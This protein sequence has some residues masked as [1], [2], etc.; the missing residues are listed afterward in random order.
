M[1]KEANDVNKVTNGSG[2]DH[3]PAGRD[4][5]RGSVAL[6]DLLPKLIDPICARKGLASSALIAAWP[7]LVGT[8]FA[9]CTLPDKID[10]PHQTSEGQISY[11]GGTLVVRVDGPK[12]VYFQHEEH[13]I[14]QR[15]NQFFGF[16]AIDRLKIVQAPIERTKKSAQE[17]LPSLSS[18]QEQK[19]REC[20]VEF[21]DPDLDAAILKMGKGVLRRE[22]S[23]RR[24]A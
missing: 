15:V 23:K 21:D 18:N 9:D 19:L 8:T 20:V 24:K 17:K 10:W 4:W 7:D 13:Q 22:L 16:V 1:A 5:R 11:R 2:W 3:G 6:S 14:L 12:A